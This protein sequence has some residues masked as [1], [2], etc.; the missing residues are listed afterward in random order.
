[1]PDTETPVAAKQIVAIDPDND[2]NVWME[3]VLSLGP[4]AATLLSDPGDLEDARA[5]FQELA[6]AATGTGTPLS[7]DHLAWISRVGDRMEKNNARRKRTRKVPGEIQ[8]RPHLQGGA[9]RHRG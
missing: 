5:Y 9:R 8:Q 4:D 7:R 6:R 3:E 1:M 2:P